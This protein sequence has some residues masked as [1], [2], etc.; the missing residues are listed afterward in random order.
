MHAWLD[1]YTNTF[2]NGRH[3][4]L[5]VDWDLDYFVVDQAVCLLAASPLALW[6]TMTCP[7]DHPNETINLKK[8]EEEKEMVRVE[9]E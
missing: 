9:I 6:T 4:H 1:R 3:F 2:I 7:I 5:V 8:E